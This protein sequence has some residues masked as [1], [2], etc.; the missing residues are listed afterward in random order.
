MYVPIAPV[1][2]DTGKSDSAG[3]NGASGASSIGASSMI[4]K[5]Y[6]LSD[7]RTFASFFHPEKESVIALVDQFMTKSG[8]FAIPGYPQKLGFL[9]HG[10]PGTGKTSF[11][12]VMT[13]LFLMRSRGCRPLRGLFPPGIASGSKPQPNVGGCRRLCVWMPVSGG[14]VSGGCP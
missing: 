7:V 1:P 2:T 11:V 6:A 14:A 12:K 3:K 8:K 9:L 5:Q 4:Y 13:F 10:P